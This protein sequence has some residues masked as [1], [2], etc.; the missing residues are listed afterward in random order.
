M[1]T[2]AV[3]G[4]DNNTIALT[5]QFPADT[6]QV[7]LLV[8]AYNLPAGTDLD[9]QWSIVK[10]TDLTVIDQVVKED[11]QQFQGS[12]EIVSSLISKSKPFI[13]GDYQVKL[14]ADSQ[15]IGTVP[16]KVQ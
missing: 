9:I 7:N 4:S 16:F 8:R 10:S 13:T 1:S 5:A 11:K 12:G 14:L 15:E 6:P 3:S 2:F